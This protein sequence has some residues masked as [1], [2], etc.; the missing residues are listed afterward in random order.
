MKKLFW[1][2]LIVG[3]ADGAERRN[4]NASFSQLSDAFYF[5][6]VFLDSR[7]IDVEQRIQKLRSEYTWKS[8]TD[9]FDNSFRCSYRR[10]D[11]GKTNVGDVVC[12][13]LGNWRGQDIVFRRYWTGGSGHFSDV[14]FCDFDSGKLRVRKTVLF[15][16]RAVDGMLGHPIF[17]GE[18]KVYFYMNL[19]NASLLKEAGLDKKII[20]SNDGFTC[21]ACYG[22]VGKCVYD[23]AEEEM[24]ILSLT[25]FS[26]YNGN[27]KIQSLIQSK[28]SN[29][30]AIFNEEETLDFLEK[31]RTIYEEK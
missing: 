26:S 19:S 10:K 13:Y 8:E 7:E 11:G 17:D 29:G 22:I 25:A 12:E 24:K 28:M 31:L 27:A 23:I 3:C 15:G 9:V 18:E 14:V 2:L 5:S 16:D 21:C 4:K 6:D 1:L 30:M 20:E